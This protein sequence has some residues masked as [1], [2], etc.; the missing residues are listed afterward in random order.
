MVK[1]CSACGSAN[2][3]C[4][5]VIGYWCGAKSCETGMRIRWNMERKLWMTYAE[6]VLGLP[7]GSKEYHDLV[8]GTYET[9]V[10]GRASNG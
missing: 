8:F 3:I 7:V 5:S 2:V 1:S 10:F 4:W 6:K 9:P